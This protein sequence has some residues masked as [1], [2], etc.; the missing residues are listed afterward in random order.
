M[1]NIE[2]LRQLEYQQMETPVDF[3]KKNFGNKIILMPAGIQAQ[4]LKAYLNYYSYDIAY[5]VDNDAYKHDTIL[6]AKKVRSFQAFAD[7][8][9]KKAVIITSNPDVV[10]KLAKQCNDINFCNYTR[11]TLGFHFY[12][13]YEINNGF[14]IIEDNFLK[15]VQ[16]Y[17]ILEDDLSRETLENKLK[18][19]ITNDSHY[20]KKIIQPKESQYFEPDI[21]RV[22]KADHFIDCGAFTGDTLNTCLSLTG[23]EIAAY[24]AFEPDP[25]NFAI[26]RQNF[27][28]TNV[29][30]YKA[31]VFSKNAILN[32]ENTNNAVSKVSP[33]GGMTIEVFS[34]DDLLRD[35]KVTFIKMDIEG[36]EA[37]ALS[38]AIETIQKNKPVLAISVYHKF[39]DIFTIPALI[40]SFGV[41]YKYYLRH[42]ME[43]YADT[44]LYAVEK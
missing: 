27:N 15:Y 28:N 19:F 44:V 18:Y 36:S 32:F 35:K 41:N 11:S 12:L 34:I 1:L 25:N 31:G 22:S 40:K 8:N 16:I 42:Y 38:G 17:S 21:Y 14:S 20:L 7:D 24:Y 10:E 30:L 26:L 37:D 2:V 9:E 43:D 4:G 29:K 23:G 13:P 39:N 33:S 5:Y 6:S 3:C